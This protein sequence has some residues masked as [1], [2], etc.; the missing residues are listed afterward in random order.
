MDKA[1]G[2]ETIAPL[3]MKGRGQ[4]VNGVGASL[5]RAWAHSL[6]SG[7]TILD[8][9][10]GTG[11]PIAKALIEEGMRVYGVD[12]SPTMVTTF[13]LNFPH[14]S[15][16]CETV[17]E[18]G[19]FQRKFGGIIAWGLLFLLPKQAQALVIQKAAEALLRGGKFLFTSPGQETSWPDAMTGQYSVSLGAAEYRALLARSGL[20]LVEEYEDEG[21]N[22]YFD[23][24]KI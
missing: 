10:C 17:E 6:P 5:V 12:A 2:Y 11:I 15:V 3:F 18:S 7:S 1:N 19:F 16:A 24:V 8:L 22:H 9:G 13:R 20:S 23:S 14:S 21:Q 4:A